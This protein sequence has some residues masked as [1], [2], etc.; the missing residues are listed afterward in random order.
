M[1]RFLRWSDRWESIPSNDLKSFTR[2]VLKK[3]RKT[4]FDTAIIAHAAATWPAAAWAMDRHGAGHC[5][6]SSC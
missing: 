5:L 4:W 3:P 2:C 6:F 1:A